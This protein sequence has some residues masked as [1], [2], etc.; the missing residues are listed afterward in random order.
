MGGANHKLETAGQRKRVW[1]LVP[2]RIDRKRIE[3]VTKTL[4]TTVA[5]RKAQLKTWSSY[6]QPITRN[7]VTVFAYANDHYA[8]H[9]PETVGLFLELWNEG[10]R[11]H[12]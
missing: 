1:W 4:D 8:G 3:N 10:K 2:S 11:N 9:G 12:D 5:D 6:L 7:G